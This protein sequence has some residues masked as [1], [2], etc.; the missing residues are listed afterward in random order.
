MKP[1][2]LLIADDHPIFRGGLRVLLDL[3]PEVEVVGEAASGKEAVSRATECRP[4]VILMDLGMPDTSGIE[5][6][7]QILRSHPTISIL[8]VTMYEDDDS[9]FAALRAG[10]RGYLLKGA[11][12]DEVLLAI[13]VVSSG[14]VILSPSIASRVMTFFATLKEASPQVFPELTEREHEVLELIARGNSNSM[15]AEQLIISPKTVRNLVSSILSKLQ[16][17][18]RAEAIVRA[19]EA[20][21][22]QQHHD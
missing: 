19:R 18:S 17:A 10:A 6:T 2:R 7:R 21:L 14:G 1:I 3:L 15:I 5:A 20:G 4:D 13:R 16:V 11:D 9:V 12:Q 22:G 8:V